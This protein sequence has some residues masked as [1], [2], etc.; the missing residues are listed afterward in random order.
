MK[1][2]TGRESGVACTLLDWHP[3]AQCRGANL[4]I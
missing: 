3:D 1:T 4:L 2:N